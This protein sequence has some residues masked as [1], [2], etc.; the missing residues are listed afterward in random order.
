MRYLR[1]QVLNR[2]APWDQ[3]LSVD[4]NN[5]VVMTTTNNVTLPSGTTAQRP[6]SPV[7]G[8]LRYNTDIVT[9]GE[10]EIYQASTWRSI[11][12]KESSQITQQN[13]GAGDNSTVY[14]GPLTPAP[15][16]TTQSNTS[17]GGQNLLVVVENVIQL[18]TTNYTIV[19]NPAIPG[20][21]YSGKTSSGVAIGATT[22]YF[23]THLISTGATGDGVTVELTFNTTPQNPFAV[24]SSVVVTGFTPVGYNGTYVVTACTTTS[25]SFLNATIAPTT[26]T[27]NIRS[28][29]AVYPAVNIA[30]AIIAG[31]AS[32]AT[33]TV[34]LTYV[35]APITD[36]LIS[37][38]ID[39]PTIDNIIAEDTEVT[40]TD[41][42]N[43]GVGYFLKFS[44]PVP[45]GKAVTV[46]HGFDK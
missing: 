36:A 9:G 23:N 11:R 35:T 20:E 30:G 19:Q 43:S 15:P 26:V 1:K 28:M 24:G 16:S 39:T 37:I 33:N 14:F 41:S 31:S 46:L 45:Y 8:M 7:N 25:V 6:V 12:F 13:L 10:M 4:I 21:I 44:S 40:I 2:R 5:A 22:I 18:S 32:F 3:R 17:W 27:G 29:N 42:A 34:I 38:T